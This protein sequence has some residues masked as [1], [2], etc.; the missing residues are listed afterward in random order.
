M[1]PG[2]WQRVDR[3][4][5]SGLP[6][7]VPPP[8]CPALGGRSRPPGR[9]CGGNTA[10][11]CKC[12]SPKPCDTAKARRRAKSPALQTI[13][14]ALPRPISDTS[15]TGLAQ[16]MMQA[17]SRKPCGGA[18]LTGRG[19]YE[20]MKSSAPTRGRQ[21]VVPGSAACLPCIVGRAF[22]PAGGACV[23][24]EVYS[25][26]KMPHPSVAWG[27]T[28]P[29]RGGFKRR[30]PRRVSRHATFFPYHRSEVLP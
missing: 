29:C 14:N 13:G 23:C 30:R 22:T 16:C 27:D 20:P 2:R 10:E 8:V 11:L 24:P 25:Q 12:H 26:G 6:P 7:P 15:R 4:S 17:S 5:I 21:P 28:S 9:V 19:P 1:R 3:R 18:D